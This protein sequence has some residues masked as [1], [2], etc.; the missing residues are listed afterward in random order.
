MKLVL[1]FRKCLVALTLVMLTACT[2]ATGE[3]LAGSEW[4][5]TRIGS[6]AILSQSKLFLQFKGDNKL[7]GYGG[8]NRF[9]AQ[10][11]ISGNEIKIGPVG[12]TRMACPKPVMDL[13]MAF[14]AVLETAKMF[15]RNKTVLVLL[16]TKRKEQARL[17]QTGA[18]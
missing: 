7:A 11:T 18:D 13:E 16:D 17:I 3:E 4:R 9:F 12:G 2:F 5:L 15:R 8:C 6:S 1:Q 14:F 10:Y